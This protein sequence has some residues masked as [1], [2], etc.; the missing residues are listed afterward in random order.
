MHLLT[1]VPLL[2]SYATANSALSFG[3][4]A[5]E[6]VCLRNTRD[7]EAY[8][9]I[10]EEGPALDHLR[11]IVARLMCALQE[12]KCEYDAVVLE[13]QDQ[14]AISQCMQ[15]QQ[16]QKQDLGDLNAPDIA[17]WRAQ[18][19]SEF[20][21]IRSGYKRQL[22][23]ERSRADAAEKEARELRELFTPL[24]GFGEE[25][26]AIGSRYLNG[27]DGCNDSDVVTGIKYYE[28]AARCGDCAC[29]CESM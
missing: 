23:R 22:S 6:R 29:C 21:R 28:A 27:D 5:S 12:L 20:V 4:A 25:L 24:P 8:G 18:V 16:Q 17:A 15:Q 1:A 2:R 26:R 9:T 11:E 14:C 10:E 7:S 19:L 3:G 13:L